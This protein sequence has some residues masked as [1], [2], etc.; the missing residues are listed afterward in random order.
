MKRLERARV[1]DAAGAQLVALAAPAL[2]PRLVVN[3]L[4]GTWLG[5]RL[6]PALVDAPIGFWT[7]ALLLDLVATA[8]ARAGADAL[9]GAGVVAALPAA[10]AGVSDW[11]HTG[12]GPA[13]RVGL[14]HAAANT[15]ALGCYAASWVAR[16][17]RQRRAAVG[18]AVA[19]YSSLL[20]GA[21]LGGHL[22]Y[23]QAIGVERK[24]FVEGPREWTPVLAERD[25]AEG[26]PRVVDVAG[27]AVLLYRS[28]SCVRALADSCNH[29]GGPLHEGT[30]ADGCVTCPWHGSTYR[31]ADGR[32][33][34]G[35]AAASQ[36]VFRTRAADGVLY[37]R[38]A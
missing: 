26:E 13:R 30:V 20:V 8:P 37:V 16:L 34:R 10:A 4:S 32:V 21:Y 3:A 15:M 6:H 12:G 17:L 25:L 19:G 29:L 14:V 23:V 31:L 36:P 22:A 1:L 7:G 2:R 27:T 28:G 35:P 24:A 33:V 5:H 9:V 11:A 18:L 38:L